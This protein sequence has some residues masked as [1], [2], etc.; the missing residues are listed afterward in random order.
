[1]GTTIRLDQGAIRGLL[2]RVSND[3]AL[4]A[5]RVTQM[6]V[7][8]NMLLSGRTKTG[9]MMRSVEI[10]QQSTGPRTRYRVHSDL[11]Y[12]GFQEDG[13]GPVFARPG[14]FLVFT[15]KGSATVV[16]AKRTSG[17]PGGHFF[18]DAR[19]DI[20]LDDFL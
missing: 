4:K 7:Q 17:F 3:A 19:R 10:Q 8:R 6:R 9:A 5:A 15:P 13:I 2:S 18:R 11:F 1:M 12:T 16:F 14:H 20:H